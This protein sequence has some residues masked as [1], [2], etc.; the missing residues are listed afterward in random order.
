MEIPELV[1][2]GKLSGHGISFA[3]DN[4]VY[5]RFLERSGQLERAAVV[6]KA[7][8]VAHRNELC[9]LTIAPGGMRI[10]DPLQGMQGVLT[11]VPVDKTPERKR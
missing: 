4:A 5:L 3:A 7:R 10:G 2:A 9:G 1:G 11:G 6:I 8:G